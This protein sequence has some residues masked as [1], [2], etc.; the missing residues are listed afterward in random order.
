MK[1]MHTEPVESRCGPSTSSGRT[2]LCERRRRRWTQ[3]APGIAR[4]F[5][6]RSSRAERAIKLCTSSYKLKLSRW[7][8][9]GSPR[10]LTGVPVDDH[11][12]QRPGR[13]V[14]RPVRLSEVLDLPEG[15]S[16]RRGN[17]VAVNGR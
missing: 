1:Q 2:L 7:A 15:D 10:P 16:A 8:P 17:A 5:R 14:A 11:S 3:S 12:R 6:A 13:E 9:P 4:G